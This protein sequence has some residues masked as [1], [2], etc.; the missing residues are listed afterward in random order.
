MAIGKKPALSLIFDLLFTI[1][2]LNDAPPVPCA[3]VWMKDR[4]GS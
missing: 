3:S 4:F 1:L 2:A